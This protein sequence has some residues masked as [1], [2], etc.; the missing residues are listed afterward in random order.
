MS[1]HKMILLYTLNPV[2]TNKLTGKLQSGEGIQLQT[3]KVLAPKRFHLRI[4]PHH[5]IDINRS[6]WDFV[7][8]TMI[9]YT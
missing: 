3:W 6:E 4:E 8:L 2:S 1:V 9:L 5:G 7:G